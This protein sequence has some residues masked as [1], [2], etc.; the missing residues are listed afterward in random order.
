MKYLKFNPAGALAEYGEASADLPLPEGATA[1]TAEQYAAAPNLA[2][3]GGQ[4][5]AIV[6]EP[7]APPAPR[8]NL[9]PGE[10]L[11]RFTSAE[12]AAIQA[13]CSTVPALA[14]GLTMGLALGYVDLSSP[15][16]ATWLQ[17][18]VAAGA[19]TADRAVAVVVP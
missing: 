15:A 19:L 9:H 12:Q 10:F 11:N 13:A 17:G 18:L 4:V 3:H 16:V 14:L 6:P 1:C 8:T 2:L 5:V 7:P